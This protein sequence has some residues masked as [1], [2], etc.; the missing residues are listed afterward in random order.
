MAERKERTAEKRFKRE[1]L[2]KSKRFSHV[3]K[4]FLN[5]ILK[6]ETYTIAEAEAAVAAFFGGGDN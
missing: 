6:N 1:V 2:L 3:Q 4:D 5:A